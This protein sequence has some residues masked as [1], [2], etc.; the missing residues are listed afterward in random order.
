MSGAR[1]LRPHPPRP[2]L[3]RVLTAGRAGEAGD[4]QR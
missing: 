2:V 1:S 4:V 3:W